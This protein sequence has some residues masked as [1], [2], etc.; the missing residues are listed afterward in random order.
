VGVRI[1]GI[2]FRPNRGID[3]YWRWRWRWQLLDQDDGIMLEGVNFHI[4]R[5]PKNLLKL[6]TNELPLPLPLEPVLL[7]IVRLEEE[8]ECPCKM[9]AAKSW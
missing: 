1:Y 7:R 4:Y 5:P 6:T 9:M 2:H 3:E 8:V